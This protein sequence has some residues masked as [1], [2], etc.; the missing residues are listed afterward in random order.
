MT[1]ETVLLSARQVD[2]GYGEVPVLRGVSLEVRRGEIVALLG[3]NGA[4]KSTT[5]LTL[6][7][8][9]R[10]TAGEVRFLGKPCTQP[11]YRRARDGLAFVIEERG[12]FMG[13]TVAQNLRL[14]QGPVEKALAYF[15]ELERFLHVSAGLLSGGQQQMLSVARALAGDPPVLLVDEL[16]LGLAPLVVDRLLEALVQARDR[17]T[18]IVLVEQHSRSALG[19][20]DRAYLLDQGRVVL[21]GR[22]DELLPRIDEIERA[23]L[24]DAAVA[25]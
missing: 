14:G 24:G 25:G 7:G 4:G 2:A 19:V 3:R 17:G 18:G 21:G 15:P 1:S 5:L 9:L 12:V 8:F 23:Y 11:A 6:A 20:A 16:S 13:L 22:A 10:P